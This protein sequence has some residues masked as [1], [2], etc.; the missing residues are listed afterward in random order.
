MEPECLPYDAL[1]TAAWAAELAMDEKLVAD[2][3]AFYAPVVDALVRKQRTLGRTYLV[4][5]NGAQGTGKSTFLALVSRMLKASHGLRVS[6]FSID[7]LYRTRGEREVLASTVHPLLR[8]RGVPGTHDVELGHALLTGLSRSDSAHVRIPVFDKATDDRA[9]EEA[10]LTVQTPLDVVIFEGWC[11]GAQAQLA[12]EL[13]APIND[14]EREEDPDG[15]FR[16]HVNDQLAGPY[17]DLFARLDTLIMLKAP[18]MEAVR[19]FRMEQERALARKLQAQGLPD[20]TMDEAAV[21]RFVSYFERITR[22]ML[23][24]MKD[25]ADIL[26]EVGEDHRLLGVRHRG[27]EQGR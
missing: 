7:D 24:D 1:P 13:E 27:Q 11:V 8:T 9:P 5:V 14:L 21:T 10:F 26:I 20:T 2:L 4:G 18:S 12:A 19:R 23:R 22:G 17:A 16:R 15:T 25:R 6:G 3:C